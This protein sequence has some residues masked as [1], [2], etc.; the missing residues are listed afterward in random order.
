MNST[1]TTLLAAR[2]RI[3]Q[4]TR[5]GP[6]R[7]YADFR[8]YRAVG[9]RQEALIPEGASTQLAPMAAIMWKSGR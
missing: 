3:F 4:R 8:D 1:A 2:R 7:Y 9:G 5:G 6:P